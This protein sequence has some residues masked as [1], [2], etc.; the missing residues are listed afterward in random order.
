MLDRSITTHQRHVRAAPLLACWTDADGR[1]IARGIPIATR[2]TRAFDAYRL[3]A[4]IAGLIE[5]R[6]FTC[7][8]LG[9]LSYHN[10]ELLLAIGNMSTRELGKALK[11]IENEDFDGHR[12]CNDGRDE[13]GRIWRVCVL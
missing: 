6:S 13:D 5:D 11:S 2:T 8:D 12:L 10:E 7:V 1:I 3:I 4:T 9:E